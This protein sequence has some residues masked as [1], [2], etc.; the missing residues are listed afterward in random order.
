MSCPLC[1]PHE[2]FSFVRPTEKAVL[3]ALEMLHLG[4]VGETP[5]PPC[6]SRAWHTLEGA[7]VTRFHQGRK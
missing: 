5:L 7:R 4:K 1:L 2:R 3:G 6:V